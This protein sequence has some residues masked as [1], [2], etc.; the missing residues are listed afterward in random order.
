MTSKFGKDN[1]AMD[2]GQDNRFP[3]QA[4]IRVY[5]RKK[6][7]NPM[8]TRLAQVTERSI[9]FL[10]DKKPLAPDAQGNPS[11]SVARILFIPCWE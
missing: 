11:D 8:L 1:S 2:R 3:D 6:K 10:S 9:I 7:K 4:G 5:P